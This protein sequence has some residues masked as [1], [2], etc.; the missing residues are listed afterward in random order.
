VVLERQARDRRS[1]SGRSASEPLLPGRDPAPST[2]VDRGGCAQGYSYLVW[3]PPRT[4]SATGAASHSASLRGPLSSCRA[5]RE[6]QAGRVGD[7]SPDGSLLGGACR[8]EPHDLG[9]DSARPVGQT[10]APRISPG[11]GE[12]RFEHQRADANTLPSSRQ[13]LPPSKKPSALRSVYRLLRV[14]HHGRVRPSPSVPS[15]RRGSLQRLVSWARPQDV[16]DALVE[17]TSLRLHRVEDAAPR[18][19]MEN[20]AAPVSTSF[21]CLMTAPRS[22]TRSAY[23]QSPAGASTREVANLPTFGPE[24]RPSDWTI[25]T[26]TFRPG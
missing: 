18:L 22:S 25:R 15:K 24:R 13:A 7:S 12:V 10:I 23:R 6:G 21:L 11:R 19:S 5:G 17:N 20:R 2:E 8:W 3:P 1:A 26:S 16:A 9:R 4:R 14:S